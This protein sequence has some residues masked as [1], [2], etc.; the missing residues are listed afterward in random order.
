M[1]NR[2]AKTQFFKTVR[3][4]HIYIS[5]ALFTLLLFF[6]ITGITL[7]NGWYDA[8]GNSEHTVVSEINELHRASWF[9][10]KE[11]RWSPNLSDILLYLQQEYSLGSLSSIDVDD[12]S[13]EL[14]IE[15]HVPS[16]GASVYISAEDSVIEIDIEKGSMLG[17]LNDLHKGRHSG[18][19][20]SWLIDISAGLMVLFALTGIVLLF[21]GKKH[22]LSDCRFQSGA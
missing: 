19:F 18:T 11:G 17:V 14:Y 22:Q 15:Y 6:S 16:G 20:W 10:T 13:Q 3:W 12:S 4:L 8:D 21:H 1:S 5:T 7:N 2:K 9:V